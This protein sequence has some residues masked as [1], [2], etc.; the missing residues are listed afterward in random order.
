MTIDWSGI[1]PF[2]M[3]AT[4]AVLAVVERASVSTVT[5]KTSSADGEQGKTLGSFSL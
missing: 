2:Y 1:E 5:V 3:D 4:P